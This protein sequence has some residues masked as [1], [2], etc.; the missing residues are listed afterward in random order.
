MNDIKHVKFGLGAS[1]LR[2]EDNAFITGNGCY[3]DDKTADGILHG[4]V[5]RSPMAH[6]R[7]KINDTSHALA[8]EGVLAVLTHED[9]SHLN[10]IRCLAP[11]KQPDGT[12]NEGRDIPILC[13]DT[14]RHVGDAIAFVVAESLEIARD[15]AELIDVDFDMLPAVSDT[16]GALEP[17]SVKVYD[18]GD[19]NLAFTHE[20][21]DRKKVAEMFAKADHVTEITLI[22]NRIISN[23]M[24][25]RAC[26]ARWDDEKDRYDVTLGSQGVFGQ[27]R[28][29]SGVFDV[30][31]EKIHVM[32]P[33]VGGGFG[34]KV[35]CYR[36][37]P[38]C[39]VAARNL[40][41]PV[42]WTSDRSEHF[43]SDAQGR[44]NVVT[45]RMA[46][47]SEGRFLAIDVDL[48]AAM[49]AYLHTFGP[50]IPLLGITMTTGLYDI[51]LA[52]TRMR[53]SYT[54]TV[55]VDA[56]RGAGRPEAAYLIERLADKCAME[57]GIGR[58]EI[59]RRNFIRPDQLPYT[60]PTGRMYDTGEF[61]A[62]M[63]ECMQHAGWEEFDA[64][65][66]AAKSEGKIRGIGISSYIEACAF[67][68]SEPAFLELKEDGSVVLKIGTQ[69]NG[70]GH[71]TAYTQLAAEKLGLDYEKIQLRQGD[72]DE[73]K[74]GGGTGGS[75][76]V[77]LGGAS[78][79]Q[80]S[81][82]LADKIRKIAADELEASAADIELENGEARIVGTDRH[83]TFADI[84]AAASDPEDL[85]GE[86]EFKQAEA[87]YPNGTH[88]C[89]VEI[90]PQTGVTQ[91]VKYTV[92]D[93]FGVTVNPI[94]LTG[95]VHGG[96]AQSIGQCLT[97]H[98]VYDDE[99]QL[100][101]AS[102]MDYAM[103]RADDLPCFDFSTRN[104][105]STTNV[106][107]IKGAGEA[108]T[109]GATPA[110]MS[111][112]VDA[113]HREYG[114]THMDM[115]ATPSRLWSAIHERDG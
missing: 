62:H 51:P 17:E 100:L 14:V 102:F 85:K 69:S 65:A 55:P 52:A 107:G 94:L 73:L 105:P 93:D 38:L 31:P 20:T 79:V 98:V 115:P 49:G 43:V 54:N 53:G 82:Q 46:M 47:N 111:A 32:T 15:A 76:S 18:D 90:D 45:A 33:D 80:A 8:M 2:K 60:T 9:V 113:L 22:N 3:T 81:E 104:V 6:A 96:I 13:S 27:R 5:L 86:G 70:Q 97:E 26:Q 23:Y 91:I 36:E 61:Q 66:S 56:Y 84:A 114:I 75:R 58:D 67:A 103:P 1:V 29:L 106:L 12:M 64:R 16:L 88:V 92:V 41:R 68:G 77:P 35:F 7:F 42:K 19:G 21:G 28:V 24:E 87:T 110:V 59:R 11:V 63:E 30:E 71:A 50:Y 57:L 10:P 109:I 83:I 89:E 72:T 112:V 108:G 99:G 95:Q 25:M 4:F 78:V 39:M 37:Y 101:T 40:G 74:N 44:D 34:T 48:V